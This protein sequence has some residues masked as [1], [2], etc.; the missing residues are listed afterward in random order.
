[1]R[2]PRRVDPS[3]DR[4]VYKQVADAL[5]HDITTRHYTPG[6]MLPSETHLCSEYG[7]GL[8]T[9]RNALAILRGE[10]LVV[11]EP[12]VGSRVRL[13]WERAVTRV[14]GD[15]EISARMPTEQ[16]RRQLGL[17]EGVPVLVVSR[18]GQD[19]EVLPADRHVVRYS[20]ND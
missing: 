13:A 14:P 18:E 20:D 9:V 17:P 7:V 4:P 2:G 19:D 10:G 12:G 16:E 5:R 11:T 3:A 1:M 6:Q 8:N 15:A